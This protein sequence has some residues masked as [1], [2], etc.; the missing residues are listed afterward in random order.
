MNTVPNE[1]PAAE[2]QPG[3]HL[4]EGTDDV[5]RVEHVLP[6]TNDDGRDMVAL[7]VLPLTRSTEPI[8]AKYP[9]DF[10]VLLATEAQVRRARDD[11]G[12]Y[13]FID[14]LRALA[15]FYETHPALPMPSNPDFI[16]CVGGGDDDAGRAEIALIVAELGVEPKDD[17]H[18][19]RRF[20]PLRYRAFYVPRTDMEEYNADLALL[21]SVKAAAVPPAD[22]EG[23]GYSR[24]AED[25]A[26]PYDPHLPAEGEGR[27]LTGRT[28][29]T[30]EQ[31]IITKTAAERDD[32][33]SPATD[34]GD[35]VD[36]LPSGSVRAAAA[37]VAPLGV[38]ATGVTPDGTAPVLHIRQIGAYRA[39]LCPVMGGEATW[40]SNATC[41]DCKTAHDNAHAAGEVR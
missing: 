29:N 18:A 36:G 7:T 16:H 15:D 34:L 27:S 4:I 28:G 9:P 31:P 2:V 22:P 30:G 39:N 38:G 24:P 21:R 33:T 6:Y 35:R 26:E 23:F 19:E 12:R 37:P 8:V 41:E 5:T 32:T 11:A 40:P 20:G 25:D 3:E 13:E 10:P 1:K 17:L 14:G